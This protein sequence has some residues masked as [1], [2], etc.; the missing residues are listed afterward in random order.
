MMMSS[1]ADFLKTIEDWA[2]MYLFRSLTEFFKYLKISNLSM[3]Q[4]YVLTY[5]YY[6]GPSKISDLCDHMMVSA[7]AA[8]QMVDRLEKQKWVKRIASAEDR[9][10]R[11]VVLSGTGEKFVRQSIVARQSWLQELPPQLTVEQQEQVTES[12]KILVSLSM[13]ESEGAAQS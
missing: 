9:R 5:V 1:Q 3:L 7:A 12:L 6:N 11:N 10:V 8:S 2:S 13:D 4:A